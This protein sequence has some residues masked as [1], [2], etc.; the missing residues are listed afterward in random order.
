MT[1]TNHYPFNLDEK[2]ATIAKATTGD[3]TVDNYFQTARYLDESLEQFFKDLKKS[4]MYKDSVIL[5]YGDHNGISENHNRAMS[6]IQGKEITPYQNAQNQRV[7]LMIRI[8]GKK[9]G[10]NHTYGG[11]V[12]VMPTLLHLQGIDSNEFVNFG[13]DLFSKS[14]MR[15]LPSVMETM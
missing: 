9:G 3:K 4:G 5:L 15:L 14:M 13:T 11:E 2:D 10:V 6:E 8:P 1:L 12:D 7:P